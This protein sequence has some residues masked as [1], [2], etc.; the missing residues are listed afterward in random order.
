MIDGVGTST[1]SWEKAPRTQSTQRA[2]RSRPPGTKV[3][4]Q[5]IRVGDGVGSSTAKIQLSFKY[6]Q[7]GEA[8]PDAAGAET[9]Q[10]GMNDAEGPS[11]RVSAPARLGMFVM[12][13]PW[14]GG[15][16]RALAQ[17][18]FPALATT[19]AGMAWTLGRR[20]QPGH[21]SI[22]RSTIFGCRGRGV[23][24]VNADF[25]RG[26]AD[27]PEDVAANVSWPWRPGSPGFD[28]GLDRRRGE[29]APRLRPG[30]RADP[31]ARG[32]STTAAP[33]SCSPPARK[34][35]SSDGPTSTR[36]SDGWR[37][38]PRPVPT[39]STLRGSATAEQVSAIVA[40]VSP[41]PVNLLVNAPFM[42][43]AEAA[44]LG[45]R[46]ISVAAPSRVPRGAATSGGAQEIAEQP[47][48]FAS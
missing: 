15:S 10:R 6:E 25:E 36:R 2:S 12:P 45:V 40:A 32:R 9:P 1:T 28:R 26:F 27:D 24:A 13:N 37:R 18:G 35:S 20:G 38:T 41:K 30:G 31:A 14:D 47:G 8:R 16:A 39:A 29:A 21:A 22:R 44:D 17:L 43:V 3:I 23:R 33:G 4:K 7:D 46:R 34:G 42:T 11:G 5:D 19:S 48:T